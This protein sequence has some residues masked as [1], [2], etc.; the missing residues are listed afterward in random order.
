MQTLYFRGLLNLQHILLDLE[1]RY[2]LSNATD[3]I[4][5]GSSAGGLAVF[6]HADLVAEKVPEATVIAVPDSGE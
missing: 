3:L 1:A 4:L 5:T 2:S 6:L